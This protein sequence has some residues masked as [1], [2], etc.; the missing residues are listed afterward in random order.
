MNRTENKKSKSDLPSD[1]ARQNEKMHSALT[2]LSITTNFTH[3]LISNAPAIFEQTLSQFSLSFQGEKLPH[4]YF[5]PQK[6]I[7]AVEKII[8]ESLVNTSGKFMPALHGALV[9]LTN[10][11][12]LDAHAY[13]HETSHGLGKTAI[14][15]SGKQKMSRVGYSF[16]SQLSG[17][18]FETGD[19]LEEATND[20]V[21]TKAAALFLQSQSIS[22]PQENPER[23]IAEYSG[24]RPLSHMRDCL[25]FLSANIP[26]LLPLLIRA[27]FE[28]NQIY[29][30]VRVLQKHYG[31]GAMQTLNRMHSEETYLND[32]LIMLLKQGER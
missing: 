3:Q 21:A 25:I 29:P 14:W 13:F 22:L 23:F 15:R 18:N 2:S 4:T 32:E 16:R 30:L 17:K 26:E 12:I 7:W 31:S 20:F 5:I 1:I 24:G 19:F 6:N 11:P 27:R 10:D 28:V 8:G 9:I